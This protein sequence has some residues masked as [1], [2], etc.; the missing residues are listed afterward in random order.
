MFMRKR[1]DFCIVDEASQL[2]LPACIGPLRLSQTFI[3]VGDHYQLPPLVRNREA[4]RLGFGE[5]LFKQLIDAHPEALAVLRNQ[6][7][8]ND[9]IMTVANQLIY[10]NLLKCGSELVARQRFRS[11][12]WNRV[13]CSACHSVCACWLRNAIDPER[14]VLFLDTDS[15]SLFESPQGTSYYNCGEASLI[16]LVSQFKFI[17]AQTL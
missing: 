10:K 3:L 17:R 2:T 11:P 6:Y 8:M 12:D 14:P 4:A 5:S 7:R 15:C 16:K 1:F 13:A 9:E